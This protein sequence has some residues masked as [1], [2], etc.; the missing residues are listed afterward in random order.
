MF[1]GSKIA[2]RIAITAFLSTSNRG[3]SARFNRQRDCQ[4]TNQRRIAPSDLWA[5]VAVVRQAMINLTSKRAPT[6]DDKVH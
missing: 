2:A 1:C 4:V 6:T 3:L 5:Q